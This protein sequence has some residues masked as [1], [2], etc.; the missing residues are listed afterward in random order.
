MT[1]EQMF[2]EI[3]YR[4]EKLYSKSFK[5]VCD[6]Y[7]I[8]FHIDDRTVD[9]IRYSPIYEEYRPMKLSHK[10]VKAIHKQMSELGWLDD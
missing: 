3:G 10:E 7:S 9:C 1:A 8:I 6:K 5:Y 2:K 4:K